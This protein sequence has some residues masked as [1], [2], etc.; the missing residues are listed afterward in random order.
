MK[1]TDA[2]HTEQK[3]MIWAEIL[4]KEGFV[5]RGAY[6]PLLQTGMLSGEWELVSGVHTHMHLSCFNFLLTSKCTLFT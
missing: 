1:L 5:R 2:K 3:T 4:S 6:C